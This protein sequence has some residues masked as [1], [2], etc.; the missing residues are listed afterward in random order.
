MRV[1][2]VGVWATTRAFISEI[3][4]Q[5]DIM[6]IYAIVLVFLLGDLFEADRNALECRGDFLVRGASGGLVRRVSASL[7]L[8]KP[9][10]LSLLVQLV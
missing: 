1:L 3:T 7:I 2:H 9:K 5:L 4:L 8:V 10:L 6:L